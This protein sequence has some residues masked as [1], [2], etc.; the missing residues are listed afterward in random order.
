MKEWTNFDVNH[1]KTKTR[2]GGQDENSF[3]HVLKRSKSSSFFS[4]SQSNLTTPTRVQETQQRPTITTTSLSREVIWEVIK[5]SDDNLRYFSGKLAEHF[6]TLLGS[7]KPVVSV[8]LMK[9][10]KLEKVYEKFDSTLCFFFETLVTPPSYKIISEPQS[11][12]RKRRK[13]LL[14]VLCILS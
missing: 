10:F 6:Q 11:A 8:D 12:H 3:G 14:M 13:Q 9:S 4:I 1:F 7:Y 2:R 5:K